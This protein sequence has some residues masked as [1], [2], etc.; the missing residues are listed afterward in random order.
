MPLFY[1][2]PILT[3]LFFFNYLIYLLL[4][5]LGLCDCAGFSLPVASRGLPLVV[6]TL[7]LAVAS[8]IVERWL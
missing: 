5:V 7:L 6:C 4:T 2:H 1:L 3:A 8:L